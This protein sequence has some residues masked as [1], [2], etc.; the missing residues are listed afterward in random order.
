[1]VFFPASPISVNAYG[2][3]RKNGKPGKS[4]Q[5]QNNGVRLWTSLYYQDIIRILPIDTFWFVDRIIE[6]EL[7]KRWWESRTSPSTN[8]FSR[9][10]SR[11]IPSCLG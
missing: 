8:P 9:G 2:L 4:D 6:L 5:I 3:L 1:V 10:I 11:G 7:N